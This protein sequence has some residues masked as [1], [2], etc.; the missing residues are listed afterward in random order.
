MTFSQTQSPNPP[1]WRLPVVW[2]VIA[3]PL[4][5]VAASVLTAYLA[6]GGEQALVV[7]KTQVQSDQ[8]QVHDT[9]STKTGAHTPARE[10]RNLLGV[11][12]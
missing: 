8:G 6:W 9:R 3:L 2:L 5:A 1:W 7:P 4:S 12:R 11:G 10:A